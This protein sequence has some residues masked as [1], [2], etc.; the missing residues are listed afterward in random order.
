MG[1]CCGGT[2]GGT[3]SLDQSNMKLSSESDINKFPRPVKDI[4]KYYSFNKKNDYIG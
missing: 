1:L 3:I 2:N 4:K